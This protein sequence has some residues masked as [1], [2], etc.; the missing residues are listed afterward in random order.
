MARI[1]SNFYAFLLRKECPYSQLVKYVVCGGISVGV[2]AIAF[3]LMAWLIF[4]CLQVGDPAAR[5]LTLLGFSVEPVS[6]EVMIRNYW[7]IKVICFFLSNGVVYVLNALYVFEGGRHRRGK[8]VV[9]FFIISAVVFLG[10]TTLGAVLI[11]RFGWQ[12][13]YT[14]GFMLALGIVANYLLRKTIVFKR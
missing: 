9:L 3:Y 12:M 5:L 14:Y 10:G 13:T 7:I 11:Q 2:D 6:A 4:P 1:L 8:E